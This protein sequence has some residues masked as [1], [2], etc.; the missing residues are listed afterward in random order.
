MVQD[1]AR[2]KLLKKR[3]RPRKFSNN[4][5]KAFQL[6][7]RSKR[8]L[9]PLPSRIDLRQE[10]RLVLESASLMGLEVVGDKQTALLDIEQRLR[11]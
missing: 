4:L 8:T 11:D 5:V 9:K 3:G 6:P 2:L 10:A 7:K 1:L